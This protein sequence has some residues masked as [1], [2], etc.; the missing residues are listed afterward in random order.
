M[1][2]AGGFKKPR[3]LGFKNLKK[4]QKPNVGFLGFY[5]YRVF[6]YAYGSY[7]RVRSL[8]KKPINL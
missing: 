6:T 8:Y 3:F 5:F 7:C 2:K 4:P 1:K